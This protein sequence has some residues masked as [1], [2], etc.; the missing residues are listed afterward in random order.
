MPYL[1]ALLVLGQNDTAA[2]AALKLLGG[3]PGAPDAYLI[4]G[5]AALARSNTAT[6]LAH[7]QT[8]AAIRFGESELLRLDRTLRAAGRARDAD[9]LVLAYAVENPQSLVAARLLA[10]VRGRGGQWEQS[11][12]LLDWVGVRSGW[13]DASL[14]AD[15]AFARLREGRADEARSLARRAIALQPASPS[16]RQIERLVTIAQPRNSR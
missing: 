1:R 8:A 2:A 12:E 14:L 4:A 11:A 9:M 16:A 10:N 3:N 13:R 15:L 5:D 6:A 7:Y